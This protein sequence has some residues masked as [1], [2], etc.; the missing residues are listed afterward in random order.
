MRAVTEAD[1]PAMTRLRTASADSCTVRAA[2]DAADEFGAVFS[3][4]F[5]GQGS[6]PPGGAKDQYSGMITA[7]IPLSPSRVT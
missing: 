3:D 6:E 2:R 4:E 5:A 1:Y 7:I